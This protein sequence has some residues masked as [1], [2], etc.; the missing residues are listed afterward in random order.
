MHLYA[1]LSVLTAL[2]LGACSLV[3]ISD[4]RVRNLVYWIAF[5]ILIQGLLVALFYANLR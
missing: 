2:A 4:S 1:S 3:C 5:P